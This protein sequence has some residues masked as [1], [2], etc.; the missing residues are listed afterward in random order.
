MTVHV[1][2]L[3]PYKPNKNQS[4]TARPGTEITPRDEVDNKLGMTMKR[5]LTIPIVNV[6]PDFILSE[7][8]FSKTAKIRNY[9]N[10]NIAQVDNLGKILAR[11]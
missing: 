4:R 6:I 9:S 3:S 2:D 1:H 5:I 8:S 10:N 7:L 11:S